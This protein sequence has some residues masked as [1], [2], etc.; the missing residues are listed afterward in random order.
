MTTLEQVEG[1]VQGL[2][3]GMT[4]Y[5]PTDIGHWACSSN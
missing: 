3:G 4:S 5:P 1:A 2:G